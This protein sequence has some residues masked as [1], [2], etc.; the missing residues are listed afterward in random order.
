M[1]GKSTHGNSRAQSSSWAGMTGMLEI[2]GYGLLWGMNLGLW[3]I[4]LL[5]NSLGVGISPVY[6]GDSQ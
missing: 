6:T 2:I 3:R 4:L 5:G 1:G